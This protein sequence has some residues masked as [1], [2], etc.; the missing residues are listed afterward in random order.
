M[1]GQQQV[2]LDKSRTSF[3]L[4]CLHTTILCL[5]QLS[6]L[7]AQLAAT[8]STEH[9]K[10]ST[11]YAGDLSIF[12]NQERDQKLQFQ[13]VMDILG[14]DSATTFA[15]IGAVSVCFSVSADK[16]SGHETI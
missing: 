13:R 8:Q 11:P 2:A 1:Q 12:V 16:C 5:L 3:L 14:I 10:T 9:R 4:R 7:A 15:D 6:S